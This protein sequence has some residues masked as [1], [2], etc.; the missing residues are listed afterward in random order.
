MVLQWPK[1]ASVRGHG[2]GIMEKQKVPDAAVLLLWFRIIGNRV[3]IPD[4]PV[5][6]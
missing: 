5:A 1:W 6:V 4:D 3:Q 2:C